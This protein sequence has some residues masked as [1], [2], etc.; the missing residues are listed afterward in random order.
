MPASPATTAS[1]TPTRQQPPAAMLSPIVAPCPSCPW[2]VT[3]SPPPQPLV[4]MA[5]LS[6]CS[7]YR[8]LLLPTPPPLPFTRTGTRLRCKNSSLQQ[9][10]ALRA[11]V[12]PLALRPF[13]FRLLL[14]L[15]SPALL[16]ATTRLPDRHLPHK[17]SCLHL[18]IRL[19]HLPSYHH[20]PAFPFL[21]HLPLPHQD[22]LQSSLVPQF[23]NFNSLPKL[24]LPLLG[25][26]T[27]L[28]PP[29]TPCLESSPSLV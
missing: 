22:A 17:P 19:H 23:P 29:S 13:V 4:L 15:L 2:P 21:H 25:L 8:A 5:A 6:A 20:P 3:R 12:Q 7:S 24:P 28:P 16:A 27:H 26:W 9:P 14:L 11:S 10:A 18:V 1:A